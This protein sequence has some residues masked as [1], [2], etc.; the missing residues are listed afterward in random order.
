MPLGFVTNEDF[1]H[2]FIFNLMITLYQL[3]FAAYLQGS[4]LHFALVRKPVSD[5]WK[6]NF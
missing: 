4:N 2:L 1:D 5:I 6:S 3:D